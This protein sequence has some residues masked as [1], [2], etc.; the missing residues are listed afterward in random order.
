MTT[1][2]SLLIYGKQHIGG[3]RSGLLRK[4]IFLWI[5]SV[6]VEQ[7]TYSAQGEAFRN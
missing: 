1:C 4:G 7:N 5:I 2:V 6:S 3:I